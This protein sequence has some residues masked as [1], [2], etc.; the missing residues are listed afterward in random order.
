MTYLTGYPDGGPQKPTSNVP[1][2]VIGST[3]VSIATLIALDYRRRT[4]NGPHIDVAQLDPMVFFFGPGVLDYTTNKRIQERIG[5][6]DLYA[7]PHGAFRCKGDD[8]WCAIAVF[9]EDEWKAF[10]RVIGNPDWTK[11]P[12]FATFESRKKSEDQL[13][14]LVEEWT[15]NHTPQEVMTIM[16]SR[17]VPAGML[18]N[19]DDI[20][21]RD[22]QVKERRF[23]RQV[24]H[25][26][27]GE[28]MLR[29]W[30]FILSETTCEIRA[31]PLIGQDNHR[32]I[33]EIL[34]MSEDEFV[35]LVNS[36]VLI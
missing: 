18:Q 23:F 31:A 11:H 5:N 33:T 19:I 36:K 27:I 34:G 9:T 8:E 21:E 6:C 12:E 14:R 15:I 17:G 24:K 2:D 4:G 10:C 30:P 16:Q 29:S 13:E 32:I 35:E 7:C 22:P 25:P 1:A 3:F 20:I 28:F 26:I